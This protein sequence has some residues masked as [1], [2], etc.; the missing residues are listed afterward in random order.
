MD[1]LLIIAACLAA[2]LIPL[3]LLMRNYKLDTIDQKVKGKV[4]GHDRAQDEDAPE[5]QR[6]GEAAQR[7]GFFGRFLR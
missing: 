1:V 6:D 4:I 2:P 5:I 7:R 3:S